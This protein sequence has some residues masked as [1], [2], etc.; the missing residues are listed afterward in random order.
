MLYQPFETRDSPRNATI[1]TSFRP[2]MNKPLASLYI[3]EYM[4]EPER[5]SLSQ[6]QQL[7]RHAE[8]YGIPFRVVTEEE[9]HFNLFR[10]LRYMGEGWVEGFTTLSLGDQPV[11][12]YERVARAIGSA[13]GYAG[14]IPGFGF[15][16]LKAVAKVVGGKSIPILAADAIVGRRI[17]PMVNRIVTTAAIGEVSAINS[18]AKFLARPIVQD[19]ALGSAKLAVAGA[20]SQWQGGIDSMM[21]G[22]VGGA[23]MEAGDRLI[24]NAMGLAIGG[25]TGGWGNQAIART[26]AGALW[27]GLPSTMRGETTPEQVY[28]YALGAFF[29]KRD[30]PVHARWGREAYIKGIIA[31]RSSQVPAEKV[32]DLPTFEGLPKESQEVMAKMFDEEIGSRTVHNFIVKEIFKSIDPD[33]KGLDEDAVRSAHEAADKIA[34][35]VASLKTELDSTKSAIDAELETSQKMDAA[36]KQT[37]ALLEKSKKPVP[38]TPIFKPRTFNVAGIVVKQ[39]PIERHEN[40]PVNIPKPLATRSRETGEITINTPEEIINRFQQQTWTQPAKYSDGSTTNALPPDIFKTPEEMVAFV[41]AHEK[42]HDNVPQ[43]PGEKQGDYENR[44]NAIAERIFPELVPNIVKSGMLNTVTQTSEYVGGFEN[45]GKGTPMGDGKDKA[46]REVADGFIG[47]VKNT[48]SSTATSAAKISAKHTG[49]ENVN[50][51][52]LAAGFTRGVL[53]P[54]WNKNAK[55]IMLA[56]NSEYSGKPLEGLTKESILSAHKNGSTFVVGDMPKV[57]SQFIEYLNEIGASYKVYHTGDKPRISIPETFTPAKEVAPTPKDVSDKPAEDRVPGT[58]NAPEKTPEQYTQDIAKAVLSDDVQNMLVA[59][60]ASSLREV[61]FSGLDMVKVT[62]DVLDLM[63]RLDNKP[64]VKDLPTSVLSEN[65]VLLAKTTISTA[66]VTDGKTSVDTVPS[67]KINP[68]VTTP[69]DVVTLLVGDDAL[70]TAKLGDGVMRTLASGATIVTDDIGLREGEY[71][72]KFTDEAAK[73]GYREYAGT[74]I[75]LKDNANA[76]EDNPHFQA[77]R[78]NIIFNTLVNE[79]NGDV[80]MKDSLRTVIKKGMG[81]AYNPVGLKRL[82]QSFF[83]TIDKN[84]TYDAVLKWLDSNKLSKSGKRDNSG[85]LELSEDDIAPFVNYM[86]R[87]VNTR[88]VPVYAIEMKTVNGALEPALVKVN[89]GTIRARQRISMI[90][91]KSRP[92]FETVKGIKNVASEPVISVKGSFAP[93]ENGVEKYDAAF[94][95]NHNEHLLFLKAGAYKRVI[96]EMLN[97]KDSNLV[98]E[99]GVTPKTVRYFYLGGK[100]DKPELTFFAEHPELANTNVDDVIKE[101]ALATGLTPKEVVEA[102]VEDI[103]LFGQTLFGY[104]IGKDGE[105]LKGRDGKL[106]TN[107]DRRI[108]TAEFKEYYWN[109]RI[110]SLLYLRDFNKATS[111]GAFIKAEGFIKGAGDLNKRLQIILNS[112]VKTSTEN[113]IAAYRH[114]LEFRNLPAED[115]ITDLPM[116]VADVD[117]LVKQGYILAEGAEDGNLY[118]LPETVDALNASHGLPTTGSNNKSFIVHSTDE[119]MLLGKYLIKKPLPELEAW[120][121]ANGQSGVMDSNAAKQMGTR[122]MTTMHYDAEQGKVVVVGEMSSF[123]VPIGTI[124]AV[125]SERSGIDKVNKPVHVTKQTITNFLSLPVEMRRDIL[126]DLFDQALLGKDMTNTEVDMMLRADYADISDAQMEYLRENIDSVGLAQISKILT[127]GNDKLIRAVLSGITRKNMVTDSLDELEAE[128]K[129]SIDYDS[130]KD[131]ESTLSG[132][133]VLLG[134]GNDSAMYDKFSIPFFNKAINKYFIN[135]ASR[136]LVGNATSGMKSRGTGLDAQQIKPNEFKLGGNYRTKDIVIDRNT[137][138]LGAMWKAYVDNDTNFTLSHSYLKEFFENIGIQR[139]PQD[140]EAGFQVAKF[141]GFLDVDSNDI[142]LHSNIKEATG[143]ADDDGDSYYAWFSGRSESGLGEGMKMSWLKE[144]SKNND[145]LVDPATGI[146][147]GP[148][149]LKDAQGRNYKEMIIGGSVPE[150]AALMKNPSLLGA[151]GIQA[152]ASISTVYARNLLSQVVSFT[153]VLKQSYLRD[154]DSGA[155]RQKLPSLKMGIIG[156][157]DSNNLYVSPKPKSEIGDGERSVA[158]VIT[159]VADPTEFS[160]IPKFSKDSQLKLFMHYYDVYKGN[161]KLSYEDVIGLVDKYS[162]RTENGKPTFFPERIPESILEQYTTFNSELGA[163]KGYWETSDALRPMRSVAGSNTFLSQVAKGL[164]SGTWNLDYYSYAGKNLLFLYDG[165]SYSVLHGKKAEGVYKDDIQAIMKATTEHIIDISEDGKKATTGVKEYL[166]PTRIASGRAREILEVYNVL[167]KITNID[168]YHREAFLFEYNREFMVTETGII[169]PK[170]YGIYTR[171]LFHAM[172]SHNVEIFVKFRDYIAQQIQQDVADVVTYR[173]VE[174]LIVAHKIKVSDTKK[175]KIMN[176]I[177][178][179]V[180]DFKTSVSSGEV[181]QPPKMSIDDMDIA[182][183]KYRNSLATTMEKDFF[184]VFMLGSWQ[185]KTIGS[186]KA[187][188]EKYKDNPTK[189]RKVRENLKNATNYSQIGLI[190]RA[191]PE[192]SKGKFYAIQ[193]HMYDVA[194]R[195]KVEADSYIDLTKMASDPNAVY[196]DVPMAPRDYREEI[197]QLVAK[198]AEHD[199]KLEALQARYDEINKEKTIAEAGTVSETKSKITHIQE[200]QLA[201]KVARNATVDETKLAQGEL[202]EAQS[203]ARKIID[204]LEHYGVKD[205]IPLEGLTRGLFHKTV[206]R[207]NLSDWRAM[208]KMFENWR[209]PTFIQKLLGEDYDTAHPFIKA[210]DYFLFPDAIDKNNMKKSFTVDK[211]MT[212]YRDVDGKVTTGYGLVPI[213]YIGKLQ[214]QMGE[215]D[216]AKNYDIGQ[217]TE[218]YHAGL[219]EYVKKHGVDGDVLFEYDV[220]SRAVE[221][222]QQKIA[223]LNSRPA[224]EEVSR[225]IVDLQKSLDEALK[226]KN[227]LYLANQNGAFNRKYMV[228]VG[229]ENVEMDATQVIK[230]ISKKTTEYNAELHKYNVGDPEYL[231]RY[232]LDYETLFEGIDLNAAFKGHSVERL[233]K[234][235]NFYDS[236]RFVAEIEDTLDGMKKV[237]VEIGSDGLSY[238]GRSHSVENLIRKYAGKVDP[239]YLYEVVKMQIDA[240]RRIGDPTTGTIPAEVYFPNI[241]E[242]PISL[243]KRLEP[244]IEKV[245]QDIKSLNTSIEDA[246]ELRRVAENEDYDMLDM[247]IQGL[248]QSRAAAFTELSSLIKRMK[249]GDTAFDPHGDEEDIILNT[250]ANEALLA[251]QKKLEGNQDTAMRWTYNDHKTRN[252]MKREVGF[253]DFGRRTTDYADYAHATI[254]MFHKKL[255]LLMTKD[256]IMEAEDNNAF[257]EATSSWVKFMKMYINDSLGNPSIMTDDLIND[258]EMKLKGNLYTQ[259]T[260]SVMAR[261]MYKIGESLGMIQPDGT[262]P[263][264]LKHLDYATV[265]RLSQLE[266]QYEMASLLAHPKSMVAN[267]WGG[268]QMTMINAGIKNFFNARSIGFI[269]DNINSKFTDMGDVTKA[270]IK[271]GYLDTYIA[272][273]TGVGGKSLSG[274][275]RLFSID[276]QKLLSGDKSMEGQT[277]QSLS[278]KYAITDAMFDKASWFMRS[279]EITLRRDAFLAHYIQASKSFGDAFKGSYDADGNFIFNPILAKMALKGVQV[280]QF[281]YT[282]P[283]RPAIARTAFGK[284]LTRFQLWTYNSINT[285]NAIYQQAKIYGFREGTEE[286]SRFQRLMC[287]DLLSLGLAQAFMF[288]VFDATLPA[289]MSWASDMANWLFGN[290]KDK[291]AAFFGAYPG[292]MAPLQMITPPAMRLVPPTISGLVDG[293]WK[294]LTDYTTWTMFPFGR[295]ARDVQKSYLNPKSFV[296]RMT[297]I[298]F[299]NM[300][301][302]GKVKDTKDIPGGII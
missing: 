159:S 186:F 89:S 273:E 54:A 269:R 193:Q 74:G 258:P 34:I 28:Q 297:G 66:I 62:G 191:V 301:S 104:G 116:V 281:L 197:E 95:F 173:A 97:F 64:L 44:V 256:T 213:H 112:G 1:Q 155:E 187:A 75:W 236:K 55:V 166:D 214:R 39:E 222:L 165:F 232:E 69:L 120:M 185:K 164:D 146:A 168:E 265:I 65:P 14:Y 61:G 12:V 40:S 276:V 47:E 76:P 180:N 196:D 145:F 237:P 264:E 262:L 37:S 157:G 45:V 205:N 49:D 284:V 266:A 257:G 233:F 292:V 42:T 136:P 5:F 102:H 9:T 175:I 88:S 162:L 73:M 147:V 156:N 85:K 290:D 71:W 82:E 91:P 198:K 46:M 107:P 267:L 282:A 174:S 84:P 182:A 247:R 190:L 87:I 143:G 208:D 51:M 119:G 19:I 215:N 183:T 268:S 220:I 225:D 229:N 271:N 22:F 254:S 108:M 63:N 245:R 7:A 283:Y 242:N 221:S 26:I 123:K 33:D 286:Y 140:S 179:D 238:L 161:E 67:K 226:A 209:T 106:V 126:H 27:N 160:S 128:T 21:K 192:A 125:L 295:L 288:S 2:T 92:I 206:S 38:E 219:Y 58:Q 280:T 177:W 132:V 158:A 90:E 99:D 251:K 93:D 249:N 100:N 11:N 253:G 81:N 188:D 96:E 110:N 117:F 223:T 216:T 171:D 194:K 23:Y 77:Y 25:A 113:Y 144:M 148:K 230:E 300:P 260:D 244:Q 270:M 243:K 115:P 131:I 32:E 152:S 234:G 241:N 43:E 122:K 279:A 137:Y 218:R 170:K 248:E 13:A 189:L 10:A 57:D 83:D 139:V 52:V 59:K 50:N 111:I 227:D 272:A 129:S 41:I 277:I 299:Q 163:D 201:Q 298:P 167:Q 294:R 154:L 94:A 259:L 153:G 15:A 20:A 178:S 261:R 199:A 6:T 142:S 150:K 181:G 118:L 235:M 149:K 195:I 53:N 56:R 278:K 296:D 130:A 135:R 109:A 16:P 176:K 103:K 228:V 275:I 200:M 8:F 204:H 78:L 211:T 291:E 151:P 24:A 17:A 224:S 293:D 105:P 138:K 80:T 302:P 169:G 127:S 98:D 246:R 35:R 239:K 101:I 124:S 79:M 231:K 36:I 86:N 250:M 202:E 212:G 203:I 263:D 18:A 114:L 172:A 141:A 31:D 30:E 60:T 287:M 72:N 70:S 4:K 3:S 134:L 48:H 240:F 217:F 210:I 121:R 285:R 68:S 207:M 184:D 29:A 289:P 133:D 274:N 252:Q 255:A